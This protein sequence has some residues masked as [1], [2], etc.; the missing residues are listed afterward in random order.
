VWTGG[1]PDSAMSEWE[2]RAAG[3]ELPEGQIEFL[4]NND[5]T[6]TVFWDEANRQNTL[7]ALN[8]LLDIREFAPPGSSGLDYGGGLQ[9]FSQ[10]QAAM[11]LS[12]QAYFFDFEDPAKSTIAGKVGYAAPPIQTKQHNYVGGWQMSAASSPRTPRKPT[13]SWPGSAVTRDRRR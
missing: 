3:F 9:A 12:W 5:A 10:G 1:I 2:V 11:F 4:L 13:S 8:L 7:D 6:K